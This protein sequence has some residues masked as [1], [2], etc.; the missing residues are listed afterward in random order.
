MRIIIETDEKQAAPSVKTTMEQ[1]NTTSGAVI[2]AISAGPPPD[3]LLQALGE[4]ATKATSK[5]VNL[6][7]GTAAGTDVMDAGNPPD[8]LVQ[9]IESAHGFRFGKT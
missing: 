2:S 6:Q 1:T 4:T 5:S 8:W 7:S 9:A 3:G